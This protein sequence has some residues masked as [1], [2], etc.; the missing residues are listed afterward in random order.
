VRPIYAGNAL[1]TVK[2]SA[3]AHQGDQRARHRFRRRPAR[4]AYQSWWTGSYEEHAPRARRRQGDRL[5]WRAL[6]SGE[7]FHKLLEP[8]AAPEL[9]LQHFSSVAPLIRISEGHVLM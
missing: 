9:P 7:N 6:G 3:D 1:A 8:L 2:S 4:G 5:R